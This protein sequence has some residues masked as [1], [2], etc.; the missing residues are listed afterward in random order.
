M[1]IRCIGMECAFQNAL[2]LMALPQ[3]VVVLLQTRFLAHPAIM[4]AM[5]SSA[6][7]HAYALVEW[8]LVFAL[9]LWRK[10]VFRAMMVISPSTTGAQLDA[11]ATMGLLMTSAN[12]QMN[13]LAEAVMMG[14][15][16]QMVSAKPN[17]H[18]TMVRPLICATH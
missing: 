18:A 16:K 3:V 13:Y 15:S 11:L 4:D 10:N 6:N 12:T 2:V 8:L 1:V 14:F 5:E 7:Q 17:V 9:R